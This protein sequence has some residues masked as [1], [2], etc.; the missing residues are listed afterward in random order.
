[1]LTRF[2]TSALQP[3]MRSP[4][5]QETVSAVV[6]PPDSTLESPVEWRQPAPAAVPKDVPAALLA[7]VPAQDE[8]PSVT[9]PVISEAAMDSQPALPAEELRS[10]DMMAEGSPVITKPVAQ[11]IRAPEPAA[12]SQ[13]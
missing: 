2:V 1:V 3:E 9:A 11:P 12:I 7:D 8:A 5:E 10:A 6:P 4:A 13:T